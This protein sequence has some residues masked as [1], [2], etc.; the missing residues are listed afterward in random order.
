MF[1]FVSRRE[2]VILAPVREEH[3]RPPR[4]GR[5]DGGF[6]VSQGSGLGFRVSGFRV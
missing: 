6:W 2:P 5:M 4:A 1:R 3:G